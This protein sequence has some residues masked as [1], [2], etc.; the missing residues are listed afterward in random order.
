MSQRPMVS[1]KATNSSVRPI[2]P[3]IQN[4]GPPCVIMP[5][6]MAKMIHPM[7]SSKMAAA[8]T[9][10]P[11]SLRYRFRSISVLAMTGRAEIDIAVAKNS[12]KMCVGVCSVRPSHSGASLVCAKRSAP[13]ALLVTS[14]TGVQR[15]RRNHVVEAVADRHGQRRVEENRR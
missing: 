10:I 3:P 2:V 6:T 7:R 14:G 1:M 9:T 4:V 15:R 8:I 5:R 13:I 12:A 11:R